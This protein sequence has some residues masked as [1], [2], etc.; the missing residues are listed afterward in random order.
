MVRFESEA[1]SGISMLEHDATKILELMKHSI[2]IP[3]AILAEDINV[4]LENLQSAV[5]AE[6]SDSELIDSAENSDKDE[7]PI[8][9][10]ARAYPLVE[11]LKAA[12]SSQEA[13]LWRHDD[14]IL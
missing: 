5:S 2:D 10:G 12:Q 3:G 8:T 14:S 13:V 1:G 6:D 7:A 11:L 4:Y 9:M